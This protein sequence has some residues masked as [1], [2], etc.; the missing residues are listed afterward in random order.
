MAQEQN[1]KAKDPKNP[2]TKPNATTQDQITNMEN[3]GQAQQPGQETPA[4]V[5]PLEERKRQ[6]KGNR[7]PG[8]VPGFGQGA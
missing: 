7:G 3:E 5:Q 4:E 8:D 2:A 1:S 6:E